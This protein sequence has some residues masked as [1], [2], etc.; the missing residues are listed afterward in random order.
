MVE[1][2]LVADCQRGDRDAQRRLY[3]QYHAQVHRLMLRMVGCEEAADLTQDVFLRVL[4]TIS[5]FTGRSQ[6]ST[7]LYRVAVNEALQHLRR[8]SRKRFAPL[9]FEPS[10]RAASP[11]T[12]SEEGELLDRALTRLDP[13]LRS[14]FV[15]REVERLSYHEIAAVLDLNEGTVGSRLNRARDLLQQYLTELGWRP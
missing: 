7:W 1:A 13:E 3:E 10:D 2:D 14:L 15:L 8:R 11:T 6:F 4:Q 9:V 5:K 12:Q